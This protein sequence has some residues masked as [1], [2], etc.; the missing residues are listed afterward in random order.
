MDRACRTRG[1]LR[2]VYVILVLKTEG[3]KKLG[4]IDLDWRI[5]LEWIV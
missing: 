5:I 4:R 2:N 1:E 3:N